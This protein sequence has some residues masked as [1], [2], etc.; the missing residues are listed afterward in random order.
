[1]FRFTLKMAFLAICATTLI[2]NFSFAQDNKPC[3]QCPS[4][5]QT[6]AVNNAELSATTSENQPAKKDE[7]SGD[8]QNEFEVRVEIEL[9][10]IPLLSSLPMLNK[11]FK[12]KK[13]ETGAQVDTKRDTEKGIEIQFSDRPEPAALISELPVGT[14]PVATASYNEPVRDDTPKCC[15]TPGGC[16][17]RP[18]P[19]MTTPDTCVTGATCN[20]TK[21]GC[22]ANE[23]GC[24]QPPQNLVTDI[25]LPSS[26]PYP[27]IEWVADYPNQPHSYIEKQADGSSCCKAQIKSGCCQKKCCETGMPSNVML[28]NFAE[29]TAIAD[30]QRS[31]HMEEIMALRMENAELKVALTAAERHAEMLHQ[32]MDLREQNAM[33]RGALNQQQTM[34]PHPTMT[35]YHRIG[36]PV[37]DNR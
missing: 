32:M 9:D 5:Q 36:G 37:P 1:M 16:C 20:E 25:P 2:A 15:Q 35:P 27:D 31:R 18:G 12:N 6:I 10:S 8:K 7:N 21:K 3:K 13:Q 29:Q 34:N 19:V 17:A 11:L 22:C 14:Y 28:A 24:C 4:C 33:L 30:H 23:K 26:Q